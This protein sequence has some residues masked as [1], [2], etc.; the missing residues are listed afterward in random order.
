[1]SHLRVILVTAAACAGVLVSGAPAGARTAPA[2][3]PFRV[4]VVDHLSPSQ[5]RHLAGRGAVGLLVPGVGATVNRRQ[6]LAAMIRGAQVNARLGGVPSGP[7][8]LAPSFSTG[9][10]TAPG[11]IVVT[12][13]PRGSPQAN[14]RRYPIAVIGRGF[15]GLLKSPT[16][17]I[18][19]LVSIVDIAPTAL[20]RSRGSLSPPGARRRS[21]NSRASIARSTRTI[22]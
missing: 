21:R 13:P 20:G 11:V 15:H 10:P 12:L 18:D 1:M 5:L 8:L 14:D 7:P 3:P 22:G 4:L 16:T 19:G 9:T 2:Q 17:R 6:A